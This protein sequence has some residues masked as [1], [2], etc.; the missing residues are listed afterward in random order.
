MRSRSEYV[1]KAQAQLKQLEAEAERLR[2]K[3]ARAIAE[4]RAEFA[5]QAPAWKARAEVA[6]IKAREL[7]TRGARVWDEIEDDVEGAL[8]DLQKAIQRFARE[9]KK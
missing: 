6:R 5:E 9:F 3:A 4:A 2:V 8:K 7:G 1:K